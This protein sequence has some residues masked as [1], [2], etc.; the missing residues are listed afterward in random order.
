[1]NI[2]IVTRSDLRPT[3][4]GA[5]VKIVETARSF[6][7][8]GHRAF[9]ATSDRDSY[10]EVL[11]DGRFEYKSFPSRY[12]AM[13][14]WPI[15][16]N[17]ERIAERLCKWVGYPLEEYF[18]YSPQFDPAWLVRLVAV[19]LVEK[20][21]VFQAEF[22][23]YGVMAHV[24]ARIVARIRK[25]A[26]RSSIVQHNVEWARLKAYGHDVGR[27]RGMETLALKMV[28]DVIA[29]SQDDKN[30]MIEMGIPSNVITIIP[31]GVDFAGVQ[32]GIYRRSELRRH[33]GVDQRTVVFF[34]GTLHYAPNTDAVRFIAE[35]LIPLIEQEPELA[36]L[37]FVI[38]G[39]N[40]PRYY[41]HPRIVF[42]GAVDDLAGHLHM[43]DVFLCPLFD[44]GGTRLKLLEYMAVGKPVLTT[45]KGAEGI[46]DLGQF[47]YVETATEMLEALKSSVKH[48]TDSSKRKR[49][50]QRLSWTNVG[51]CY[52]DL[53]RHPNIH[54]GK[55]FFVDLLTR[56]MESEKVESEF[57]PK[58]TPVKERTMLLLINRGCN[59]TCSFC[60]L[61]DNPQNMEVEKLWTVLDDAMSIG[62]KVLVITGGEPLLHPDLAS[63]IAEARSRGLAVNI[64]TNGLLLKRHWSWLRGSGV[65]SLSFSLDG[66]GDVHDKLRGQKGAYDRTVKAIQLVRSESNI[67][68]SVYCTVTNQNV[69]QLWALYQVC[70][71]LGVTLDF[72]PV[73]DAPDLYLTTDEHKSLWNHQVEA[74]I[75]DNPAYANRRSFYADSLK[76]HD[77]ESIENIR[78]LGFVEQYGV[79]YEG[80]FL[81]CCVWNGKGLVKGNVFETPLKS[82]WHSETIHGCRKE[83]VEEG[84]SVG[85]FNHSLYEYRNA[86]T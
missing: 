2:C 17:G 65:S 80:N 66:I 50:A 48:V 19:G 40:P 59:L 45:H 49:L 64:T 43:A 33:W 86:T 11:G 39:L 23:G 58:Y 74:I 51:R 8:L 70:A 81:P 13:Q 82:L 61:W 16:G 28:D 6:V 52:L 56:S 24:T 77:G 42:T 35:Q 41:S 60:D 76:Y 62:T 72:W 12:R 36:S 26:V 47:T 46:P 7:V 71:E 1:M 5:A 18:L 73:N 53:Y 29:V 25:S 67:P 54:Q 21:D 38:T 34:H 20:I 85:C 69:H 55:D 32:R 22:P 4:H 79:T 31:H 44:G 75:N 30:I 83:M 68:C 9:I 57:L 37:Q 84:C 15:I 10:I 14:E 27:I 78:C 3:N 63:V